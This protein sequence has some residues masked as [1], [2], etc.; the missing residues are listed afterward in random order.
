MAGGRL[1][2]Q[3]RG[4]VAGD[5]RTALNRMGV[6]AAKHHVRLVPQNKERRLHGE[7]VQTIKIEVAA[8]YHNKWPRSQARYDH[9]R[10][11]A[12]LGQLAAPAVLEK[13]FYLLSPML[14]Y[15]LYTAQL[16][17]DF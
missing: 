6:S 2:I 14:V 7:T 8:I 9:E 10:G 4:L 13:H 1:G 12:A 3:Q 11:V 15:R 16:P 17:V 5:P